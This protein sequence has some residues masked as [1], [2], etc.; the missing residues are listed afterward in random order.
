MVL[1]SFVVHFEHKVNLLQWAIAIE[2]DKSAS[3]WRDY[4]FIIDILSSF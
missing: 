3:L 4:K 2:N 1:L